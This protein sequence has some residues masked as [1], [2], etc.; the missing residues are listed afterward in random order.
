MN[1][2]EEGDV[3]S[4]FAAFAAT[5][6]RLH[7]EPNQVGL[8]VR[9]ENIF[10]EV[11]HPHLFTNIGNLTNDLAASAGDGAAMPLMSASTARAV[12]LIDSR[13]AQ[14]VLKRFAGAPL[15]ILTVVQ[16]VLTDA[17]RK[18][19][20]DALCGVVAGAAATLLTLL[21]PKCGLTNDELLLITACLVALPPPSREGGTAMTTVAGSVGGRGLRR[22]SLAGN[23]AITDAASIAEVVFHYRQTL[24]TVYLSHTGLNNDVVDAL[25]RR[26]ESPVEPDEHAHLATGMATGTAAGGSLKSLRLLR[27]ELPGT[28][29]DAAALE[30]LC[31]AHA[32]ADS[33]LPRRNLAFGVECDV[34]QF[35]QLTSPDLMLRQVD[36]RFVVLEQA[37]AASSYVVTLPDML[38]A[39]HVR[40]AMQA[41]VLGFQG[42]AGDELDQALTSRKNGYGLQYCVNGP[43]A[44][45]GPDP[46]WSDDR[47][48]SPLR[49]PY[50]H[51]ELL[52]YGGSSIVVSSVDK[53]TTRKVAVKLLMSL[54]TVELLYSH[55]HLA[56]CAGIMRYEAVVHVPRDRV[57]GLLSYLHQSDNRRHTKE[58]LTGFRKKLSRHGGV[59]HVVALVMSRADASL[60]KVLSGDFRP[61]KKTCLQ[62]VCRDVVT[63]LEAV[64]AK[65]LC[66]GDVKPANIL[67]FAASDRASCSGKP[68]D[69]AGVLSDLAFSGSAAA[70]NDPTDMENNVFG[71]TAR[72]AAPEV[73]LTGEC[74]AARDVFALACTLIEMLATVVLP[75]GGVAAWHPEA[76]A[77]LVPCLS[78][79]AAS[80]PSI[81]YLLT[82]VDALFGSDEVIPVTGDGMLRFDK[83]GARYSADRRK[84]A[85]HAFKA[86][87]GCRYYGVLVADTL[88]RMGKGGGPS[89]HSS[90]VNATVVRKRHASV[91]MSDTAPPFAPHHPQRVSFSPP[92]SQDPAVLDCGGRAL[93]YALY[94]WLDLVAGAGFTFGEVYGAVV[95]RLGH[96]DTPEGLRLDTLATALSES[97]GGAVQLQHLGAPRATAAQMWRAGPAV[98]AVVSRCGRCDARRPGAYLTSSSTHVCRM[99]KEVSK[100]MSWHAVAL[101]R[102]LP[103]VGAATAPSLRWRVVDSLSPG[104]AVDGCRSD[105]GTEHYSEAAALTLSAADLMPFIDDVWRLKIV[106]G[107]R[108]YRWLFGDDDGYEAFDVLHVPTMSDDAFHVDGAAW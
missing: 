106:G 57:D 20:I 91:T 81:A 102:N 48:L 88:S 89:N 15:E 51:V 22:W 98:V 97:S 99:C 38:S 71:Y 83:S 31:C 44:R 19:F 86:L 79:A 74:S 36:K 40:Q 82:V 96:L 35:N 18:P 1:A 13:D 56:D 101:V 4:A 32:A 80:R 26:F 72:Y 66:H 49:S 23:D 108:L 90:S 28:K 87:T 59:D 8:L 33:M 107:Q 41:S 29:V 42:T 63:A 53:V 27:V 105:G 95:A 17:D 37:D 67:L 100:V 45:G 76:V 39:I 64:H 70:R 68:D 84:A 58:V 104:T 10:F 85:L 3:A 43:I 94:V 92:F 47:Y 30:R 61:I 34:L 5:T 93:S 103:S 55:H 77:L 60:D 24:L 54:R 75:D 14:S 12:I 9:F 6:W 25:I 16:P 65:G 62:R 78:P 7:A 2:L 46:L 21:L 50:S 69:L 11:P 52:G 73:T